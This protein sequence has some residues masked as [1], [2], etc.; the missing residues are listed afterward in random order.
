[1]ICFISVQCTGL[2][3]L[4]L[5]EQVGAIAQDMGDMKTRLSSISETVVRIENDHGQKLAALFDGQSHVSEKVDR[6]ETKKVDSHETKVD[7]H[8]AVLAAHTEK[9]ELIEEEVILRRIK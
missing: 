2:C 6:L 8:T 1:M 9:L 7:A 3:G 5:T 4:N